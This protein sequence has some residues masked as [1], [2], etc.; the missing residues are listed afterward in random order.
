MI[1]LF[2]INLLWQVS[3]FFFFSLVMRPISYCIILMA[4]LQKFW[5]NIFCAVSLSLFVLETALYLDS[6]CW[7]ILW[8]KPCASAFHIESQNQNVKDRFIFLNRLRYLAL[9][10]VY[11]KNLYL[12]TLKFNYQMGQRRQRKKKKAFSIYKS[13][14]FSSIQSSRKNVVKMHIFTVENSQLCF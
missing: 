9:L 2:L 11:L 13:K 5:L 12:C 10:W 6:L 3:F 7:R 4:F 1:L 8:S 14:Y